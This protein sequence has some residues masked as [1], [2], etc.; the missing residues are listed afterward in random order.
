MESANVGLVLFCPE[1]DFLKIKFARGSDRLRR[2][3]GSQQF[4]A[5]AVK[6]AKRAIA[7]R[8]TT[9]RTSFR[10]I[11]DLEHFINTRANALAM[12]EARPVKVE[13]AR[14]QLNKLFQE[15]VGDSA[16]DRRGSEARKALDSVLRGPELQGRIEFDR[17]VKV[18]IIG[19]EL[20]AP[21]A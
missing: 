7:K 10:T 18:P 5:D 6:S 13:D 17:V 14:D 20:K 11:D 16:Q 21:Y 9:E 3:F 19:R 15:L 8:F 12:T 1:L 4:N 2:F